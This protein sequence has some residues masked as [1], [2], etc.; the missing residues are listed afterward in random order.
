MPTKTQQRQQHAKKACVACRYVVF[1]YL[2]LNFN[3]VCVTKSFNICFI[4]KRTRR[5]LI[6]GH[7]HAATPKELNALMRRSYHDPYPCLPLH[8]IICQLYQSNNNHHNHIPIS[9]SNN[10]INRLLR[11][12]RRLRP[13]P[14]LPNNSSTFNNNNINYPILPHLIIRS[15]QLHCRTSNSNSIKRRSKLCIITMVTI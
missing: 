7:A 5:A 14:T 12:L 4:E 11:R 13:L 1:V 9:I 3:K 10:H 6:S 15:I 2:T 8:S